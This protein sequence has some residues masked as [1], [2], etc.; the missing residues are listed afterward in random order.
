MKQH[1][2]RGSGC[3]VG[4]PSSFLGRS[5]RWPGARLRPGLRGRS[6]SFN[7]ALHPELSVAIEFDAVYLALE[8]WEE[9]AEFF[10]CKQ[11]KDGGTVEIAEPFTRHA[12]RNSR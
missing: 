10:Q 8:A 1:V 3:I 4:K 9:F 2:Q 11:E 6:A 5:R 7:N 12:Y